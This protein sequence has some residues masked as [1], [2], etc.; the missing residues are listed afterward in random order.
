MVTG[1]IDYKNEAMDSCE[2]YDVRE[3]SWKNVAPMTQA[4]AYHAA[5]EVKEGVLYVFAGG[6]V[7]DQFVESIECYTKLA[8]SWEVIQTN[9][10]IS[11]RIELGAIPIYHGK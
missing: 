6:T 5:V 4:R 2:V 9:M 1:G 10:P 7:K 3:N 8:N 11:P